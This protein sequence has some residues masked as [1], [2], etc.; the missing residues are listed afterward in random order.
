VAISAQ[1]NYE[2]SRHDSYITARFQAMASPCEFLFDTLDEALAESLT[3][4]GVMEVR[5]I[6]K[7]FSRYAK[8]NLCFAINNANGSKVKIDDECYRLLVFANTCFELSDGMFDLTSGV[9]RR[10]WKFDC[11]DQIPRD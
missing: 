3:Q 11:S 1:H 9:L 10:A 6:E 8:D 2:L 5:R 4:K 7:I